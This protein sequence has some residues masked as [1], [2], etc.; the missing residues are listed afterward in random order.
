MLKYNNV[1]PSQWLHV[2][3]R[4]FDTGYFS[5]AFGSIFV[6]VFL[7]L[8]SLRLSHFWFLFHFNRK[9]ILNLS[10]LFLVYALYCAFQLQRRKLIGQKKSKLVNYKVKTLSFQVKKLV[11]LVI[12][13]EFTIYE[14]KIVW[15]NQ[16]CGSGYFVNR[17][18]FQQNLDSISSMNLLTSMTIKTSS[19]RFTRAHRTVA[20]KFLIGGLCISARGIWLCAGGINTQ[21]INKKSTDL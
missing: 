15:P 5:R 13:L 1:E 11:G 18:R 3:R 2:V 7:P 14:K 16:G 9:K 20:R 10:V 8:V 4:F 21:K 19:L 6:F 17:F 12:A